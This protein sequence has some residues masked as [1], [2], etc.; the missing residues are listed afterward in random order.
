MRICY[1]AS[2]VIVPYQRGSSI[3]AEYLGREL[4]KR[5]HRVHIVCRRLPGQPPHQKIDGYLLHRIHRGIVA[6]PPLTQ[7][8]LEEK[9]PS[10]FAELMKKLLTPIYKLYLRLIHPIYVGLYTALIIKRYRID[11]IIERE[12]SYGAGAI[13]SILTRKPMVVAANSPEISIL[14]TLRAKKIMAYPGLYPLLKKHKLMQSK[15]AEVP[16]PVD[17][18]KFRPDPEAGK[19]ARKKLGIEEDQPVVAYV[20]SFAPWHGVDDLIKAAK[21]VLEKKPNTKF[22]MIGPHYQKYQQL[23]HK[24]ELEKAFIFTGP[25]PHDEV[26]NYL[27][28][29]DVVVAPL[30]PQKHPLTRRKGMYYTPFKIYEALCIGKPVITTQQGHLRDREGIIMLKTTES[31]QFAR[32]ITETLTSKKPLQPQQSPGYVDMLER[33]LK[34]AIRCTKTLRVFK[35]SFILSC[36]TKITKNYKKY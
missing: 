27:N 34:M 9:A 18:E 15:V 23:V 33:L 24:L 4:A 28:A 35:T 25:V 31:E 8:K 5:G 21:K 11:V 3:H 16:V 12:S 7:P 22:L 30:N 13:A 6:E 32:V 29:A 14:S 1:V 20:G 10:T 26:P 2:D 17:V 36:F 19:A